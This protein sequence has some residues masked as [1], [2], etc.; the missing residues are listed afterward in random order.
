MTS[1]KFSHDY[2]KL[3]INANGKTALLLDVHTILLEHQTKAFLEFDTRI[4]G[5][6]EH[7]PLPDKGEF[8]L[9]LFEVS[10]GGIFTTLRRST[11]EKKAYYYGKRGEAF[12]IE[13]KPSQT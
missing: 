6:N 2:D 11:P 13:V 12:T 10:G 1:I 5:G 3:P 9:L 4:R 8:L 7:Y